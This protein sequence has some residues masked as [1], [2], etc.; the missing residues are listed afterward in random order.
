MTASSI[1]N[2]VR[3][4]LEADEEVTAF[5]SVLAGS[6][7]DALEVQVIV[8]TSRRLLVL[9]PVAL[10]EGYEVKSAH[11]RSACSV[12]NE[13]ELPEGSRILIV[14]QKGGLLYI[15]FASSWQ[16]EADA[17]RDGLA[18]KAPAVPK[19]VAEIPVDRFTLIQEFAGLSAAIDLQGEEE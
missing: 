9:T 4:A 19:A 7:P 17:I 3:Y 10:S 1:E 13:K 8:L 2:A 11:E 16:K 6:A 18:A 5:A 12:V 15:H 14:R